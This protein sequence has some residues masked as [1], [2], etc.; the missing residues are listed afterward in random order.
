MVRL[1]VE[2]ILGLQREGNKLSIEPCIP[3]HWREYEI[4]YRFDSAV[5]H[6]TVENPNGTYDKVTRMTLD[7]EVLPDKTIT[8]AN[9]GDEHIVKVILGE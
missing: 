2:K 4:R 1:A 6:I 7:G 9:D 8:L 5:Y 3:A